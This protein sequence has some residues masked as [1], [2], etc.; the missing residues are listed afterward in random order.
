MSRRSRKARRRRKWS[1]RLKRTPLDQF[2]HAVGE[3]LTEMG[4]VEFNMIMVVDLFNEAGIEY[5]FD[6][7]AAR[8][9]GK[10]I[11]RMREW[12]QPSEFVEPLKS[13]FEAVYAELGSLLPK[14]NFVVHGETIEGNFYGKPR[15]PYR[16]GITKDNLDYLDDLERGK[17][18]P[19]IFDVEQI[20]EATAS[21]RKIVKGLVK[22]RS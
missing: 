12:C 5:I 16:I 1:R 19:H 21:C 4:R 7:M 14:R 22:L 9:F 13:Q 10:K 18:G 11:E 17:P 6:D 2:N 20:R 8:T 15:Q 3:F